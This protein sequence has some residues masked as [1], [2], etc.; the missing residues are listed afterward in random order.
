MLFRSGTKRRGGRFDGN[1]K[2]VCQRDGGH[3]II[4][5]VFAGNAQREYVFFSASPHKMERGTTRRIIGDACRMVV[6]AGRRAVS[7]NPAGK[8]FGDLF[9]TVNVAA[10]DQRAVSGQELCKT[11]EGAADIMNIFKEIQMI[12]FYIKDDADFREKTQ[13]TVG[14]LTGFRDKIFGR[15]H[16]DIAADRFIDTADGKCRIGLVLQKDPGDHGGGGSL[17]VGAADGNGH[18]VIFHHL[19]QKLRTGQGR[20]AQSAGGSQ[21]R[22]VGTNRAGIDDQ[23]DVCRDILRLLA[24]MH[25][26]ALLLQRVCERGRGPVGAGYAK[27]LRQKDLC[28]AA[29]A[30]AADADEIYMNRTVEIDLVHG[31][32]LGKFTFFTSIILICP[33]KTNMFLENV[34]RKRDMGFFGRNTWGRTYKKACLRIREPTWG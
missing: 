7:D 27:A 26:G 34:V 15:T 32:L 8:P 29:H 31:Y 9:E 23:V 20:D 16:T 11:V 25:D 2:Q 24:V 19:A 6:T 12:L 1:V 3:C 21:F 5:I 28:Q 33:K 30:D 10:Y 4:D 17:A 22:I 18:L 13:E 14:I